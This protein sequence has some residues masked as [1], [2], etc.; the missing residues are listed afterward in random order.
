MNI[1]LHDINWL[2]ENKHMYFSTDIDERFEWSFSYNRLTDDEK[3][4]IC[5]NIKE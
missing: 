3:N 5:N 1:K 2:I 4:I